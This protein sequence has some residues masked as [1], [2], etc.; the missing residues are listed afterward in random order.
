M[1]ILP[2]M[3]C[4]IGNHVW[5][6]GFLNQP[7][8]VCVF[9]SVRLCVSVCFCVY[10]W[11]RMYVCLQPTCKH[12]HPTFQ[13]P[14]VIIIHR[15]INFENW[16]ID[17]RDSYSINI[18]HKYWMQCKLK[19]PPFALGQM[20]WDIKSMSISSSSSAFSLFYSHYISMGMNTFIRMDRMNL[21]PIHPPRVVQSVEE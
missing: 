2:K 15:N 8:S 18:W 4:T 5:Q 3:C 1:Q 20:I 14:Y 21:K 12:T 17:I 9:V 6:L 10:V 19:I 13:I 16:Q 11:A 7:H